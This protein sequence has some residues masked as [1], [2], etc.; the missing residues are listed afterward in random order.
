M[1]WG[2]ALA[3]PEA[4]IKAEALFRPW[5]TWKQEPWRAWKQE[6]QF[7]GVYLAA[8]DHCADHEE[9]DGEE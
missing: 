6:R 4:R 9:D 5:P 8:N 2:E 1:P 7:V 3:Y